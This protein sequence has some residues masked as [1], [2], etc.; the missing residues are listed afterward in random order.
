MLLQNS[1]RPFMDK[2]NPG[3]LMRT[4]QVM[5]IGKDRTLTLKAHFG[6]VQ[7]VSMPCK[8]SKEQND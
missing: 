2:S 8:S 5:I 3:W 7:H 4:F 6:I 1:T